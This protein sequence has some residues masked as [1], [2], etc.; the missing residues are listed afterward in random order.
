MNAP[1]SFSNRRCLLF[2]FALV[3]LGVVAGCGQPSED[4]RQN[5]RLADGLLTAVT[6]KNV[7]EL[8]KCKAMLDK[9]REDGVLSEG[10]HKRLGEIHAQAKAGKW[11]EAEAALYK[12]R[13][14]DPFPR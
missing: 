7:K 3:L 14:S 11:S 8:D 13:E 10:N 9:R 12:F 4:T 5:R 1:D 6:I 2:A